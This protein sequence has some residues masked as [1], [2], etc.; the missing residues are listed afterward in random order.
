MVRVM[1][2]FDRAGTA[3][4]YQV[5]F[6]DAY[7]PPS[8][9]ETAVAPAG[10]VSTTSSSY[11]DD[12]QVG[13]TV[14]VQLIWQ[15]AHASAVHVFVIVGLHAAAG[16]TSRI[17]AMDTTTRLRSCLYFMWVSPFCTP[18]SPGMYREYTTE[19]V[20]NSINNGAKQRCPARKM[21]IYYHA[22]IKENPG[23]RI[24]LPRF[25]NRPEL[26]STRS[27]PVRQNGKK[28]RELDRTRNAGK[29]IPC[30]WR[31]LS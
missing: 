6:P 14:I 2:L 30:P 7:A 8:G 16:E 5:Y 26:R 22:R 4:G 28:P 12:S 11:A 18:D 29:I 1:G 19:S 25:L 13:V 20:D 27:V 31:E 21:L 3:T 15:S 24:L 17:I 23:C 9:D 10:R